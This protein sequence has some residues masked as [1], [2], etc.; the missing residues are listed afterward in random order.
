[1]LATIEKVE[2]GY[3]ARYDRHLN[4]SVEQVWSMLTENDKLSQWFKELSVDDLRVGGAIK[5]DMQD[6]T[7]K[8]LKI[9]DLDMY[10]VLAYTWGEDM[11][12]FELSP[13]EEGCRLILTESLL[14]LTNHTPK[15][16]AGWHVCLEVIEVLLDGRTL[17]SRMKEWEKWMRNMC[18]KWNV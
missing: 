4:H 14:Q 2:N 7:F 6:G 5:F 15:D 1:M 17:E 16:L 13:L 10:S 18:R 8:E 11:V 12:R 9:T 3:T